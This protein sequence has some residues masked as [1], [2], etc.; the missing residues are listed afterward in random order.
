MTERTL[1]VGAGKTSEGDVTL[2][3]L[4]HVNP[5][6]QATATHLPF[7]DESFSHVIMDQV[8]EHVPHDDVPQLLTEVYRVLLPGGT[9]EARVPHAAT[10][11][12]DQDP[13][14]RSRWT[15]RTPE[16]YTDGNFSWY[17]D[18]RAFDFALERRKV[19]VWVY[20]EL[21]L[22]GVRSKL[23]QF[24]NRAFASRDEL[25]YKPHVAGSLHFTL[26]KRP[27]STGG[28]ESEKTQ[29]AVARPMTASGQE[30]GRTT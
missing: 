25:L 17:Y 16:Y 22:S 28:S 24:I 19:I 27:Q 2:D 10:R 18:N 12:A 21:P 20:P 29:N 30:Q 26:V 9:L 4:A 1:N 11:L 3:I 13:T 7:A 6:V 8:L 14:H 23:L 5:D 15:Y